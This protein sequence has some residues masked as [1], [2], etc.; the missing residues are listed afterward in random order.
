MVTFQRETVADV[1]R[2][3]CELFAEH[4]AE[5]MKLDKPFDLD[6]SYYLAAEAIGAARAYTARIDGELV[7]YSGHVVCRHP[8]C[9]AKTAQQLVFMVAKAHRRGGIGLQ[10]LQ[11]ADEQLSAESVE[12]LYQC[13]SIEPMARMLERAGYE[14][15]DATYLRRI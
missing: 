6:P 13:A 11:Y 1:L 14:M 4:Y 15:I 3:G 10:F 9:E 2:D 8:M 12:L 5:V 7:G